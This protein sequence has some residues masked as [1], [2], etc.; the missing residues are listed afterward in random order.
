MNGLLRLIQ[1]FIRSAAQNA[2][3]CTLH[4]RTLMN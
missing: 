4:G 2:D 1:R 3:G